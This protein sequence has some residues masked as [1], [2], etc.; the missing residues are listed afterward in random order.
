M[1]VCFTLRA[2]RGGSTKPCNGAERGLWGQVVKL[3]A[4]TSPVTGHLITSGAERELT[5]PEK[6]LVRGWLRTNRPKEVT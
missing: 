4:N 1:F 3:L 5:S 6:Q 2:G